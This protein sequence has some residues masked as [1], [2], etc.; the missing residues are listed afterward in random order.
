VTQ[1]PVKVLFGSRTA[2]TDSSS[3]EATVGATKAFHFVVEHFDP[4]TQLQ[5]WRTYFL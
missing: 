3:K 1:R 5:V 4:L 2:S